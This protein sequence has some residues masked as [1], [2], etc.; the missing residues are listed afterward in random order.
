MFG[1]SDPRE[2]VENPPFVAVEFL[3]IKHGPRGIELDKKANDEG[4]NRR[5]QQ[6]R[7]AENKVEGSL[8][9]KIKVRHRGMLNPISGQTQGMIHLDFA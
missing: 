9:E 5:D 6:Q 1:S 2:C 7:A 3:R 4:R 8:G